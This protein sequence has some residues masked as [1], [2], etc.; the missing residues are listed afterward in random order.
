MSTLQELRDAIDHVT[1]CTGDRDAWKRGLTPA[2]LAAVTAAVVDPAAVTGLLSKIRANNATLFDQ[3]TGAPVKPRSPH[4]EQPDGQHGDAVTA[5]KK[6]ED[7]LAQQNSTA[8]QLD[9]HVIAAILTAHAKTVEGGDRLRRLQ[10]EIEDSVRSRTDLD[11][12]S[13]ARDFQR[14]L[15]SRLREIGAVVESADLDDVSKAALA[16]AWTALYE[17]AGRGNGPAAEISGVVDAA[18]PA[19]PYSAPA[20]TAQPRPYWGDIGDDP[21]LDSLPAYQT[22]PTGVESVPTGAPPAAAPL[23]VPSSAPLF[24]MPPMSPGITAPPTSA[25]PGELPGSELVANP[26]RSAGNAEF[27]L[28]PIDDAYLT[29]EL[30]AEPDRDPP[31]DEHEEPSTDSLRPSDLVPEPESTTVRLPDGGFVNAPSVTIAQVMRSAIEGTPVVEA[32]RAEGIVVPPPGT[33]VPHPV[34]P[35][36]IVGG[37]IGMFTDR[38][39][40]ALDRNRALLDGR[41]EP[42]AGIAGPSFLG[43]L[44]PQGQ[45]TTP[46]TVTPSTPL[47]GATPPP[48]RP[49][50]AAAR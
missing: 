46:S 41:V 40:L 37:D 24:T 13:G 26:L 2:D 33:A 3:R 10:Q 1:A 23:P 45:D 4:P 47:Q 27:P 32:F 12:P 20:P 18:P 39:A 34:D 50:T 21:L 31:T 14:Y 25:M 30:L 49:A 16:S 42:V 7:T 9:L 17:A 8:A 5:M 28:D 43:W 48:T 38:Q 22:V 15:I 6:A 36:R 44:H 29:D 35:G 11:T 19:A